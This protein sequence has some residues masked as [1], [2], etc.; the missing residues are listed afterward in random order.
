MTT[1]DWRAARDADAANA[2]GSANA[3]GIAKAALARI[4]AGGGVWIAVPADAVSPS[5]WARLLDLTH[6]RLNGETW[7][8]VEGRG[9]WRLTPA[10]LAEVAGQVGR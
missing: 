5:G 1:N 6:G 2:A 9:W 3:A 4:R 10:Q 8:L 7:A